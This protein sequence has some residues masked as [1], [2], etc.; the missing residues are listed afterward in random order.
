MCAG[1][2]QEFALVDETVAMKGSVQNIQADPVRVRHRHL[3]IAI[4]LA[5][6]IGL[7]EFLYPLDSLLWAIKDRS[8][9]FKASGDIVFIGGPSNLSDPAN[10]AG[11]KKVANLIDRLSEEGASRIIVNYQFHSSSTPA[12]DLALAQSISRHSER[13]YLIKAVETGIDRQVRTVSTMPE[14]AGTARQALAERSVDFLGTTWQLPLHYAEEG[15]NLP[16]FAAILAGRDLPLEGQFHINYGFDLLS[17]PAFDVDDVASGKNLDA[18]QRAA[19]KGATI[20]IAPAKGTMVTADIPGHNGLPSSFVYIYGAETLKHGFTRFVPWPVP[21]IALALALALTVRLRRR[22]GLIQF[23]V[24][25]TSLSASFAI[26][27]AGITIEASP[28]IALAAIYGAF[29]LWANHRRRDTM[30]DQESGLPNFRKLEEDL[31]RDHDPAGMAII[32]AKIHGYDLAYATLSSD[33]HKDYVDQ[34]AAR[35]RISDK[36]LKLYKN[37]GRYFAWTVPVRPH[38]EIEAHLH[39]LRAIFAQSIVVG[40]DTVDVGVTFGIDSTA[41]VDAVAKLGSASAAV[42]QS[43]EAHNPI[44]FAVAKEQSERRWNVSLQAKID[45]AIAREHTYVVYQP[46]VS[47][48]TGQLVGAEALVRWNDPERGEI[49]PGFFIEQCEQAGRMG[50]LTGFVMDKAIA[51]AAQ[52]AAQGRPVTISINIS[53]TSLNTELP[54]LLLATLDRHKCDPRLIVLEITE[55]ARIADINTA[56]RLL[57]RLRSMGVGISIDDFGV[58]SATLLALL[59]LPFDEL[60]ID[61]AFVARMT[62]EPK[63]RAIVSMLV[64]LGRKAHIRVVAEGVEDSETLA[65]LA[66]IGCDII[67]GFYICR[68]MRLAD[69]LEFQSLTKARASKQG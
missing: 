30:F 65:L 25:V 7:A 62:R 57:T 55:T 40:G 10:P 52:M 59:E 39:G 28:A 60:K 44:V 36:A 69:F 34:I 53:A 1:G 54:A 20:V 37:P 67:Q 38:D 23:L 33:Q 49:S 27:L 5:A 14:I 68:P 31:G 32:V 19:I 11:R 29:R 9:T 4:F 51:T 18:S 8:A 21:L 22:R 35:L 47:A 58:G 3:A 17:I 45:E 13:I 12:A 2:A 64:A 46:Q 6:L 16:S 48:S 43:T 15:N 50:Q 24:L 61:R 42:E 41:E 26:S 63:A 56:S 66:R